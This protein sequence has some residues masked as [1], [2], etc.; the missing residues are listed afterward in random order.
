MIVYELLS[1]DRR[2]AIA[3]LNPMLEL[4]ALKHSVG[5]RFPLSEIAAAHEAVEA[6]NV[7]GN[8]VLDIA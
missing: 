1:E 4:G 2:Q 5:A 7:I 6:G 8:V 3:E